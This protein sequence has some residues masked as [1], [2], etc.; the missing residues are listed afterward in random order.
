MI[1]NDNNA[2]LLFNKQVLNELITICDPLFKYSENAIQTFIYHCFF[3]DNKYLT[4]GTNI[5][6]IEFYLLSAQENGNTFT[7][8]VQHTPPNTYKYFL[9]PSY[10]GDDPILFSLYSR[11]IWNGLSVLQR[12][13]DYIEMWSFASTRENDKIIN[14]YI[15]NLDNIKLFIK[16]FR[17]KASKFIDPSKKRVPLTSLKTNMDQNYLHTQESAEKMPKRVFEEEVT[18]RKF[19]ITSSTKG[20]VILTKREYECLA[21]IAKGKTYK[22]A[23]QSLSSHSKS[24]NDRTVESHINRAKDKFKVDNTSLLIA[25]YHDSLI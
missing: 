11:N 13:G 5:S 17:Y 1:H 4:V 21:E 10:H 3:S 18:P 19:I 9:W 25:I 2:A 8:F 20:R 12:H 22:E 16:S 24:I 15:N 23:A 14:F 6:W 7:N